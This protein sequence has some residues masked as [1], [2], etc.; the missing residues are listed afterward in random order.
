MRFPLTASLK[1]R[2]GGVVLLALALICSANAPHLSSATRSLNLAVNYPSTLCPAAL[3]GTSN[4]SLPSKGLE[5]RRINPKSLLTHSTTLTQLATNSNAT[6]I[7]GT[8][9]TPVAYDYVGNGSAAVLCTPGGVSQW[10]IGGSSAL[11]SQDI[12]EVINSGLSSSSV[13]VYPYTSKGPLAPIGLNIKANSDLQV[14]VASLAPGEDSVAFN[15]VTQTGRVTSYLLDHR[16]AGLS[17]LG[18]S[19]VASTLSAAS[20]VYIG[21][22]TNGRKSGSGAASQTVRL[23]VPGNIDAN[24][25]ALVYS[26]NGSFAPIGL[27]QLSVAHQKVVDVA[28]PTSQTP[29]PYGLVIT[30]DQPLFA[31]ALT[32]I[33]QGVNDLAWSNS[34][35]PLAPNKK[36][37]AMVNFS[38]A[39]PT[40]FFMGDAINLHISWQLH[41]G[42]RGNQTLSGQ[43]S[44]TWKAP[45]SIDLLTVSPTSKNSIYGGAILQSS[46]GSLNYLPLASNL[47]LSGSSSPTGD[48][49]TLAHGA[50]Y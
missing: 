36:T 14:P 30:S 9:G 23:L 28:L 35:T 17:D 49:G 26:S 2:I 39:T 12:L 40:L 16:R 31:S 32:K 3:A 18:V 29:S 44:L 1:L 41:S 20:S 47:I 27:N 46:G 34:L 37:P 11:S 48:I 8:S 50:R 21:G 15:I 5:V 10:F 22:I 38:G 25:S 42:G 7:Q 4:I 13:L 19:F 6:Y 33:S 45:G 43:G 24:V